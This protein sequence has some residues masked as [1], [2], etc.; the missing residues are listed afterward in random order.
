MLVSAACFS[1]ALIAGL[2]FGAFRPMTRRLSVA[3]AI[4]FVAGFPV[5]VAL[6]TTRNTPRHPP[7]V[8][9]W[10]PDIGFTVVAAVLAALFYRRRI[11]DRTT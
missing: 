7:G 3:S 5:I 1:G 4:A 9:H 11:G 2:L 6:D 10:L 8:V